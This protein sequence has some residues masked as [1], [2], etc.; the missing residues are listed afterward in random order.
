MSEPAN[1][2]NPGESGES[3]GPNRR[4][5]RIRAC[6]GILLSR[7]GQS[8]TRAG[9]HAMERLKA[10]SRQSI[11]GAAPRVEPARPRR[12]FAMNRWRLG[13]AAGVLLATGAILYL[14]YSAAPDRSVAVLDSASETMIGRNGNALAGT[15]RSKLLPGDTLTVKSGGAAAIAYA[16]GTR[17][18]LSPDTQLELD[19]HR[20][21]GDAKRVVLSRGK[22]SAAISK[23]AEGKPMVFA[24]PHAEALVVGTELKLGVDTWTRLDVLKGKVRLTGTDTKISAD[25]STGE[26]AVAGNAIAPIAKPVQT[27][28]SKGAYTTWLNGPSNDPAYF[29]IGVW[30]QDPRLASRYQ[31]IGINF[32]A[33]LREPPTRSQLD[34]LKDAK[35]SVLCQQNAAALALRADPAIAGWL[36]TE[37]GSNDPPL[38]AK[39]VVGPEAA[40]V[41]YRALAAADPTRPVFYTVRAASIAS[42]SGACDGAIVDTFTI[43]KGPTLDA[44]HGTGKF[45]WH[46][47]EITFGTD[48]IPHST[49]AWMGIVAGARGLIWFAHRTNSVTDDGALLD[50]AA[51]IADIAAVNRRITALAPVLNEPDEPN[52]V[53]VEAPVG[54]RVYAACRHHDG[55]TYVIAVNGLKPG[56]R[57]L[58]RVRG[59]PPKATAEAL[60]EHRSF[61]VADGQFSDDFEHYAVHIYRIR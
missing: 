35:M 34:S 56:V 19:A 41:R 37:E 17:I 1:S 9:D 32:Y 12:V 53:R 54:S 25:V 60:D 4:E 15:P 3:G 43:T 30:M 22:L 48:H 27:E 47:N 57:A 21:W 28:F 55:A 6:E 14:Y 2:S 26:F 39:T 51:G 13:A 52:G 50:D 20:E 36:Y 49:E 11:G 33:G 18:D 59:L 61:P 10:E 44:W 23:Q 16:D 40:A 45:I 46:L 58:F 7:L 8:A 31:R 24:T 29:P 5:G 42:C 38:F